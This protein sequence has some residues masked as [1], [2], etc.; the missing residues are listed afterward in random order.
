MAE[1]FPELF[2]PM[3]TTG[4]PSSISTFSNRLK[5]RMDS[6]VNMVKFLDPRV[7]HPFR[8][9]QNHVGVKQEPAHFVSS[10]INGMGRRDF[11]AP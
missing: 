5:L 2:G 10:S 3:N 11:L 9:L 7:R 6:F 1:V 4:F 8:H